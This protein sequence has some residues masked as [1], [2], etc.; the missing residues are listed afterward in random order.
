M[1][2][3]VSLATGAKLYSYQTGGY[4]ASSPA[5]S[6]DNIVFASS[7]GFLYD[8]A[9]GGG[10]EAVLPTTRISSPVDGVTFAN[11][12]GDMMVTG[13]ATDPIAVAEVE[14]AVQ[15]DSP[16]G[17]WW[18]AAT[19]S[20]SPGPIN[21]LATLSMPGSTSSPWSFDFPVPSSGGSYEVYANAV[22]AL[23]P[24]DTRGSRG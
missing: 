19:S 5:V 14:V 4:I 6:G 10:N 7:N 21:N 18:D 16:V 1:S 3:S 17:P 2:T 11:P 23:G 22:S 15:S 20:W 8:F 9:L 13:S 12:N 24:S